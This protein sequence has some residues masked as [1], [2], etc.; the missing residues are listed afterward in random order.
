MDEVGS[1]SG[2]HKVGR[3]RSRRGKQ[4]E[5]ENDAQDCRV[6]SWEVSTEGVILKWMDRSKQG[7]KHIR[8]HGAG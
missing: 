3:M 8:E 2:N 5:N 1:G 4:A 6:S 7:E